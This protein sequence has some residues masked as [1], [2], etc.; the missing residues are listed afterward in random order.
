[1]YREDQA[2]QRSKLSTVT[3]VEDETPPRNAQSSSD[4]Q[5][6]SDAQG[7]SDAQG[8]GDAP[9]PSSPTASNFQLPS[10][11]TLP[12]NAPPRSD[13]PPTS[14][15][16]LTSIATLSSHPLANRP[17]K[18]HVTAESPG[19][20]H[21]DLTNDDNDDPPE[22]IMVDRPTSPT[23]SE[24]EDMSDVDLPCGVYPK[25]PNY[26]SYTTSRSSFETYNPAPY[27]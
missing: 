20:R 15:V 2:P 17:W 18:P 3:N 25:A 27:P 6:P 9:G 13:A 22:D 11:P 24:D 19:A 7:F 14:N 10:V 12:S 1:M 23:D 8:P 5:A 21:S 16:P 26:P 4:A